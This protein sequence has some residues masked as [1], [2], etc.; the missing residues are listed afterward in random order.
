MADACVSDTPLSSEESQIFE[1][2]GYLADDFHPD[3][4][5]C[6]LKL[7]LVTMDSKMECPWNIPAELDAYLSKL[8]H[9]S[10]VCRLTLT[11][12]KVLLD[13]CQST[14]NREMSNEILVCFA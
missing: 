12:E 13:A 3:A 10:A 1:Q 4:H 8:P 2:L 7:S 14:Q 6:R 5:A 11:E 9:V